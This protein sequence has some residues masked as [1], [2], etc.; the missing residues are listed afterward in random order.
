MSTEE[1][2]TI[3]ERYVD[4]VVQQGNLKMIDE[5]M[6]PEAID[7]ALPPGL[8]PGPEGVKIFF[9]A[10]RQAFPDLHYE[11]QDVV[12]EGDR[13]V[14]RAKASGTMKG[15]FQGMPPTGKKATWDEIH[16]V[17]L[18]DGKIVEHW[19]SVDRLGMLQQLGLIPAQA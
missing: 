9:T 11:V 1:N 8:P 10:L 17:R 12:A 18:R 3:V 4:E 14:R 6:S 19:A 15:E 5:Y 13:V 2:K 7:H 16:I